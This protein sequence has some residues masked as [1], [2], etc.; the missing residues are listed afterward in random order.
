MKSIETKIVTIVALL[1]A[2]FITG[3]NNNEESSKMPD[4]NPEL[5][6]YKHSGCKSVPKSVKAR[7]DGKTSGWGEEVFE[8]EN[9]GNGKLYLKHANA[10]FNCETEDIK[11]SASI[12]G[13]TINVIEQGIG[14]SANCVCPFDVEC[15]IEGLAFGQ[16]RVLVYMNDIS[17]L[18]Y[19][20]PIDYEENMPKG[21]YKPSNDDVAI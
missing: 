4:G 7:T 15:L 9:K 21:I 17:G 10:I 13:N 20:F 8:Y 6:W 18:L 11:V 2:L 19:E 14:N 12:D 3:C 1:F 5:T 16:Y